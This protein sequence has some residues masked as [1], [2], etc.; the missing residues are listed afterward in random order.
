MALLQAVRV[1]LVLGALLAALATGCM[2]DPAD[3][4]LPWNKQQS[5]EGSPALPPGM[6]QP[7]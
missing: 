4:D 5:W 3:G 7:R 1:P 6:N 2:S